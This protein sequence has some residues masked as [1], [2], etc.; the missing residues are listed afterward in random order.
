MLALAATLVAGAIA[1][2]EALSDPRDGVVAQ[3]AR[4][5]DATVSGFDGFQASLADAKRSADQASSA[6]KQSADA[7]AGLADAMSLSVFGVRPLAPLANGFR[8]EAGQLAQLAADLDA[9]G[10]DLARDATDVATVRGSL[11][12]LQARLSVAGGTEAEASL[13][14]LRVGLALVLCWLALPAVASAVA[15]AAVLRGW[16]PAARPA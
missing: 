14:P 11:A 8:S 9:L 2:L 1:R 12:T 6:A 5:L 16:E 13:I 3:A 15:G 10:R 7:A 4:S